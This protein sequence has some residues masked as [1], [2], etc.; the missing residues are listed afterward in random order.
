MVK[1]KKE[2]SG[3]SLARIITLTKKNLLR[4]FKNPKA[5]GFLLGIPIMYYLIIG[6]VF[7]S[8]GDQTTTY[9]I[10]WVDDDT[11]T[12]DYS[13]NPYF[14]VS[15]IKNIIE[16]IDNINLIDYNSIENATNGALDDKI[17]AFVYIPDGFE[18]NLED[19]YFNHIAFWNNDT[20]SGNYSLN[21]IYELLANQSSYLFKLYNVSSIGSTVYANFQDY[22]YDAI[23]IVNENFNY[24]LENNW[25]VNMTYHYR[26]GL[27]I[28]KLEYNRNILSNI[29]NGISFSMGSSSEIT[30]LSEIIPGTSLFDPISY[31]IYFLQSVSLQT[32]MVIENL[33]ESIIYGVINYNPNE[34][35]LE[36]SIESIGGREVNQITFQSAGLILYG[37]MTILSFA[38]IILTSEKKDGIYKR[39][40]SSEVKNHEII[41]SSIIADTFLIFM[42]LTIG[43]CLLFPFGWNP[44]IASTLDAIIG[45]VLGIFLFSFFILALAFT[46]TPIFKDPDTAGGGVWIILIPLMMLSGIFFPLEYMGESLQV[47]ANFLP[48]RYAVLIFQDLLLNGLPVTDPGILT[49]MGILIL[50]SIGLFIIGIFAFRKFKR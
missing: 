6:L 46:L 9:N 18:A 12:A 43:I 14:N 5:M 25:D 44:I 36:L 29:I 10:G 38:I 42:Q 17:E 35:N 8:T 23:L 21:I 41:L 47:I 31:D 7:G 32:R 48:T 19:R 33:F 4:F 15:E 30:I 1:K 45:I 40:A 27:S 2:H 24:G 37:P 3:G 22:T 50:Y 11:S 39:L 13:L 49:N 20:S 16:K 28:A 34:I 26:D